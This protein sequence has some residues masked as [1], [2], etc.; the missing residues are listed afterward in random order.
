MVDVSGWA[1]AVAAMGQSIVETS[2]GLAAVGILGL[3]RPIPAGEVARI[4]A[5]AAILR[6]LVVLVGD[7]VSGS[8]V[9][10][11]LFRLQRSFV[12]AAFGTVGLCAALPWWSTARTPARS[13]C[14]P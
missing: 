9:G 1:A 5:V 3:G 13:S 2:V 4:L 11:Y 7:A 14:R 8:P 12:L 6:G 10:S